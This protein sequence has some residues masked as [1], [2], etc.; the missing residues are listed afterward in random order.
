MSTI[1]ASDLR[2][3]FFLKD[4]CSRQIAKI[5]PGL[6]SARMM[7]DDLQLHHCFR[8]FLSKLTESNFSSFELLQLFLFLQKLFQEPL[9]FQNAARITVPLKIH[10]GLQIARKGLQ[11][12]NASQN[13][14]INWVMAPQLKK[15]AIIISTLINILHK[16]NIEDYN[17]L[18]KSLINYTS[19]HL[20]ELSFKWLY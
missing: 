14:T 15:D 1:K 16:R 11:S 7:R 2:F 19:H 8:C 12:L 18:K 4:R 5:P 13:E 17:N 20:V 9:G 3:F 10:I 6:V